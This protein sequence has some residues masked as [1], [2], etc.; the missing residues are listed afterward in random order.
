MLASI[1]MLHGI[2]GIQCYLQQQQTFGVRFFHLSYNQH[3]MLSDINV[4]NIY[5][6]NTVSLSLQINT[7]WCKKNIQHSMLDNPDLND[8][9]VET[10]K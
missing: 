5:V 3:L 6:S 9:S 1:L 10:Y 4:V 8:I 7:C 2:Y